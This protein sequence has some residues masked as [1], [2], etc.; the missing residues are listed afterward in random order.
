MREV[1]DVAAEEREAE[2]ADELVV[3]IPT[4]CPAAESHGRG[5]ESRRAAFRA[6]LL[7][8]TGATERLS[9]NERQRLEE[10]RSLLRVFDGASK[11]CRV[12]WNNVPGGTTDIAYERGDR[13]PWC[14]CSLTIPACAEDVLEAI[15]GFASDK[16]DAESTR[17]RHGARVLQRVLDIPT[18]HSVNLLTKVRLSST[19][20]ADGITQGV[21]TTSVV[22]G[23]LEYVVA[24]LPLASEESSV[25]DSLQMGMRMRQL[26]VL[27]ATAEGNGT[28]LTTI[29]QMKVQLD[30]CLERIRPK[31]R[32]QPVMLFREFLSF[33][34]R[35]HE[36][37]HRKQ[38]W[39]ND[40]ESDRASRDQLIREFS[41]VQAYS[42]EEDAVISS[43]LAKLDSLQ[44][45]TGKVR[46]LKHQ[47]TVLQA[48]T[49][50]DKNSGQVVGETLLIVR[51]ASPVEIVAYLMD[52]SSNHQLS[53]TDR[54][55][56]VAYEP[57]ALVNA[58]H[59]VF[60][61][62]AKTPPFKN[63]TFLTVNLWK[64]L[65]DAPPTY[66]FV[67]APK[68]EMRDS[69][70]FNAHGSRLGPIP[71]PDSVAAD[72]MRCFRL[73]G[74]DDGTTRLEYATSLDLRGSFPTW[75]TN[76]I[77]IPQ[78]M[79]LPYAIQTYPL[80]TLTTPSV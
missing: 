23:G 54:S 42:V 20:L 6:E 15:L 76:A 22:Q 50:L 32:M 74:L 5:E 59:T 67:T 8:D 53:R 80:S 78:L 18:P 56:Y 30:P 39:L 58:H 62:E 19:R 29:F 45:S 37:E 69:F 77:I 63:R 68:Q 73:T 72:I 14:K 13:H 66:V 24:F 38:E 31:L 61:A 7:L 46:Q 17:S 40:T 28:H 21:W 55:I 71:K 34:R 11:V 9:A 1:A 43:A 60:F 33:A 2:C 75:A 79:G 36:L 65:S 51:G 3:V 44:F 57:L 48:R 16:L 70:N 41:A 10:G 27:Q 64:K 52:L 49:T 35:H 47:A 4:D 12:R 26:Y 25:E